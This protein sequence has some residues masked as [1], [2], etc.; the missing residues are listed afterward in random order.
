MM[1]SKSVPQQFTW[2]N[3][4]TTREFRCDPLIDINASENKTEN[5][6]CL[7]YHKCLHFFSAIQT[8]TT[9]R[10]DRISKRQWFP[11]RWRRNFT[12]VTVRTE[13]NSTCTKSKRARINSRSRK[14]SFVLYQSEK[15]QNDEK[16]N[17]NGDFPLK[18]TEKNSSHPSPLREA[19]DEGRNQR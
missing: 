5:L 9:T 6:F 8:T 10:F 13:C 3:G 18:N 2:R 19:Y 17:Q 12:I 14:I 1:E 11:S 16:K 15:L 7:L 4:I